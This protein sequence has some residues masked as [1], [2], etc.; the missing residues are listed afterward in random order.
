MMIIPDFFFTPHTDT[1]SIFPSTRFVR[2]ARQTSG[3]TMHNNRKGFTLIEL[4]IVVVIVGILALAAIPLI[5]SNTRDARRAEGEQLMG[6]ARDHLRVQY[7]KT[8]SA[9]GLTL[10]SAGTN[11]FDGEY[12]NVDTYTAATP[13]V[14]ANAKSTGDTDG[15]MNWDWASG[16]SSI[17][18]S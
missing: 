14:L 7:S 4:L 10:T 8:G 1:T 16:N 2:L 13:S 3:E 9:T 11:A 18:W 15:T 17:S 12:F 5:T 6:A